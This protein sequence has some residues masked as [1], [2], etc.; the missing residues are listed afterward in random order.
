MNRHN[1]VNIPKLSLKLNTNPKQNAKNLTITHIAKYGIAKIASMIAVNNKIS[2][3]FFISFSYHLIN[4]P[5][6]NFFF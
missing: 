3:N 4:F 1:K 2:V 6:L 5:S